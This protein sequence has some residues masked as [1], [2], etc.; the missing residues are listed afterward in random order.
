M[1]YHAIVATVLFVDHKQSFATPHLPFEIC[2]YY[3]SVMSMFVISGCQQCSPIDSTLNVLAVALW[4]TTVWNET[5]KMS[6]KFRFCFQNEKM[7]KFV[8]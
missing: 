6:M 8:I 1:A 4:D 5:I 2:R 3:P 7:S